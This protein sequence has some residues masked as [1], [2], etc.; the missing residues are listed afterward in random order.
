ME[1]QNSKNAILH[2]G[3]THVKSFTKRLEDAWHRNT[4]DPR[5][6]VNSFMAFLSSN[7]AMPLKVDYRLSVRET[8]IRAARA[9]INLDGLSEA[10]RAAGAPCV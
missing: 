7:T 10:F 2:L 8:F 6:K 4:I 5:D 3:D 9:C 1:P